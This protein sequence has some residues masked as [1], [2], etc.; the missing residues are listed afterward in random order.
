MQLVYFGKSPYFISLAEQFKEYN[1]AFVED[2]SGLFHLFAGVDNDCTILLYESVAFEEDVRY[3]ASLRKDYPQV[4]VLL[5]ADNLTREQKIVYLKT[6]VDDIIAS[7]IASEFFGK[8][9]QFLI[10]FS[11]KIESVSPN[12]CDSDINSKVRLFVLPLWK[13]LFDI[14]FS[15]MAILFLSPLLIGIIL[16]IRFESE[17]RIIYRSKRVGSNY[18]A[19]DFLKFRSMY[20]DADKRLKEFEKLNQYTLENEDAD[21]ELLSENVSEGVSDNAGQE[22]LLNADEIVLIADDFHLSESQY[23]STRKQ[24]QEN[25]FVKFENDP[26]ITRV[27]RFIR[28]YS[29]DE[30]PQLFNVLKGD[31]SIVGNRPL[32]LYEAELLT[33][34]EYVDR[35]MAPSGL[36]GLWQ[37]EKRGESG[38]MSAE[39]RKMLDIYYAN[40]FS[41]LMDVKIILKTF[42]AFIQ[43][44]NV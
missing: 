34:D 23:L 21:V 15:S 36:T 18:K 28:K 8:K 4:T 39:E 42:T 14:V 3:I 26:R 13:R 5:V 12:V 40:N 20:A 29:I 37:V 35:F 22:K 33:T 24:K 7:D 38:K 27:G 43:K 2:H 25:A 30:L 9:I 17:G 1:P 11:K 16:A 19:F 6:G 41:F 44:E 31:M 32:P 10:D